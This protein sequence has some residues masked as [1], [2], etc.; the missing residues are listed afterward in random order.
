MRCAG[1]WISLLA[2]ALLLAASSAPARTLEAVQRGALALCAHP[3]A[4]PFASR[5]GEMPGFQIELAEALAGRIGATLARHWVVNV[6]QYRRADCDIVLD[7]IAE[8]GVASE[9]PLRLSRPYGRAGVVGA[10]RGESDLAA[11]SRIAPGHRVG[12]QVGSLAAMLLDRRGVE[13]SPFAVEAEMLEALARRGLDGAAVTRAALGWYNRTHPTASLRQVPAFDDAPELGWN[14]AVG[15][16]RPDERLR[17]A[18]DDAV[19]AL[20]ADGTIARIY[21]R[22]GVEL[23]PPE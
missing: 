18:I 22:Y 11:L 1:G 5:K 8:E 3:D 7:A 21:T 15:M 6:F 12:V 23:R 13:I 9:V 14:V 10:V 16:L 2:A 20:V 19:G 4:L 17:E